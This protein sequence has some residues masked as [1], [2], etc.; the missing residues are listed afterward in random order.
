MLRSDLPPD[1]SLKRYGETRACWNQLAGAPGRGENM[2]RGTHSAEG[3]PP[4]RL[5]PARYMMAMDEESQNESERMMCYSESG[6][7]REDE[8]RNGASLSHFSCLMYITYYQSK[9]YLSGITRRKGTHS[10]RS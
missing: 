3:R 10:L 5:S 7:R 4:V 9:S 6:H 2:N 1:M 8:Y